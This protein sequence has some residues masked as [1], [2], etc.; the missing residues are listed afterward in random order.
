MMHAIGPKSIGLKT[1]GLY[2]TVGPQKSFLPMVVYVWC[3]VT[4]VRRAANRESLDSLGLVTWY[5]MSTFLSLLLFVAFY[6]NKY[7][8]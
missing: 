2:E 7:Y 3:F 1:T 8:P 6:W 5:F 4:V